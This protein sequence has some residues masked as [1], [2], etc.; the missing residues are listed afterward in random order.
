MRK[1]RIMIDSRRP[2]AQKKVS[3]FIMVLIVRKQTQTK[4]FGNYK[5]HVGELELGVASVRSHILV[6]ICCY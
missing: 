4:D 2:E 5:N 1:R 3:V 6:Q